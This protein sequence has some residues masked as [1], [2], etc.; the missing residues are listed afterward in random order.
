MG[1]RKYSD[2]VWKNQYF[3]W[4]AIVWFFVVG[5]AQ[6]GIAPFLSPAFVGQV[7]GSLIMSLIVFTIRYF[8]VR[9]K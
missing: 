4:F 3:Y 2:E 9:K 6:G 7:I 1:I 5:M 8:M